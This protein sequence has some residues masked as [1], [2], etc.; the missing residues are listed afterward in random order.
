MVWIITGWVEIG[1]MFILWFVSSLV[2]KLVCWFVEIRV[3]PDY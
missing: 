2:S 3:I 1:A